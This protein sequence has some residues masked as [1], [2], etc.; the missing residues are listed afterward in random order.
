MQIINLTR[1]HPY[2]LYIDTSFAFN[3]KYFKETWIF[4]CNQ[5]CQHI[6]AHKNIK[7][8]QISKIIITELHVENISGLLG[9]LSSLSLINR[10]KGLHIY[11]PA[12][13]E[14]YIELGKKYSQTKFHY[15]LYL[16]VIKTGLIINNY[17]HHVYT[18]INDKYRLEFNIIN[19]E[20]YGKF[21]LNKAKS[22][23][24]TVGPLYARLK[25]GYKFV[26]PDGYILAGNN[27]TS[28]NSPG[29]KISFI[30]YK[31]HQRSSIEISSKSKIFENKIY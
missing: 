3:F 16:H 15:N 4:N 10:S 24:L 13:L 28:K 18:L 14:K 26:L 19:K 27:F 20:T 2:K 11:S 1:K 30:N 31:Y 25:Q 12:G 23:N 22:F 6:L 7:I 8:S 5:G 21:E 17:T 9:L 29:I